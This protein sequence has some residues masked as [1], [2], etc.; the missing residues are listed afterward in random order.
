MPFKASQSGNPSGRPKV[1]GEIRD[2]A[3]RHGKFAIAKLVELAKSDNPRVAVAACSE[4]LDRGYG[5]PAQSIEHSGGL[6]HRGQL[7]I[8][9]G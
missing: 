8:K 3:R 9:G 2:L 7:I 5:R 4:L 1:V 6:E